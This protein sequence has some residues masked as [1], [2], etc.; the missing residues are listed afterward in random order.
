MER[1]Q[2]RPGEPAAVR[3]LVPREGPK[4]LRAAHLLTAGERP[5]CGSRLRGYEGSRPDIGGD[6][7][8]RAAQERAAVRNDVIPAPA[9]RREGHTWGQRQK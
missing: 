6:Q 7:D 3:Y 4:T 1:R 9:R 8:V 5:A 2:E